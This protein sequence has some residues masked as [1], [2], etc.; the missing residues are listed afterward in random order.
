MCS[1]ERAGS[2]T[3]LAS[4]FVIGSQNKGEIS[5]RL[6][7]RVARLLGKNAT[8]RKRIGKRLN[9]IYSARSKLSH[10]GVG[11]VVQRDLETAHILARTCL[12]KLFKARGV[13]RLT[14]E[15]QLETWLDDL[16]LR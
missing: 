3:S 5:Y 16:T 14:K 9:V 15:E 6:R 2:Q 11:G 12:I 10:A 13:S 8:S 7:A 1:I 4:A